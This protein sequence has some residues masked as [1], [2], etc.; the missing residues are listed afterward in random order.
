MVFLLGAVTADLDK[1]LYSLVKH[2]NDAKVLGLF[3]NL[4][5]PGV[6]LLNIEVLARLPSLVGAV[7]LSPERIWSEATNFVSDYLRVFHLCS[8]VKL[9]LRFEPKEII[10]ED[11][12]E[13]ALFP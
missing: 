5:S 10:L 2:N 9:K 1:T 7:V 8:C 6:L 4:P 12:V 13:A 11:S 3:A